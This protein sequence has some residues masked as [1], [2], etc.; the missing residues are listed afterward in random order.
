MIFIKKELKIRRLPPL[1]SLRSFE[2]AA[3]HSSFNQ[4]A[5]SLHV[6]PSAISHQIKSLEAFLKTT[7]FTR[8]NRQVILTAAGEKYLASIEHALEEIE[9]ATR[10]LMARPNV[11]TVNIDVAPAFL[12]R[13]L[14]PR[15]SA[16][17]EQHPDVELRLSATNARVDFNQSDTDMAIYLGQNEW[18]D[19]EAHYLRGVSM[20]MVCSPRLLEQETPLESPADLKNHCLLHITSRSGEWSELL[21]N[22]G[23]TEGPADDGQTFSSTALAISAAVEGIGIALTDRGL[24]EHELH[25]GLLTI[26]FKLDLNS[27]RAFYLAYQKNRK[28]TYG[29]KAFHDWIVQQIELEKKARPPLGRVIS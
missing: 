14:I 1:N 26:P 6:T 11:S 28:M 8:I 9:T 16:F 15:I 23:I 25:Y 18:E 24:V 5:Q 4:A 7:L 19:T 13:W 10:R 21:E 17:K 20:V 2:A 27:D 29:M 3:R 12:T 22:L